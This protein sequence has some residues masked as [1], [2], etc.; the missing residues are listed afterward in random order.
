MTEWT[1]AHELRLRE[2]RRRETLAEAMGYE[3]VGPTPSLPDAPE[4]YANLTGDFRFDLPDPFTDANDD[5]AVLDWMREQAIDTSSVFYQQC[6][7][8]Y[9]VGDIARAAL[10]YLSSEDCND[11]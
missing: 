2:R 1:E 9:Q 11:A 7:G 4:G 5:Y 8:D 3:K 6:V 10:L